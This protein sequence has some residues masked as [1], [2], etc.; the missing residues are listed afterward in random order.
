[1]FWV[2]Q[3]LLFLNVF[4]LYFLY[5]PLGFSRT[6]SISFPLSIK[7]K[8]PCDVLSAQSSSTID[9]LNCWMCTS[10]FSLVLIFVICLIWGI[11][12]F[13]PFF[14]F[15]WEYFFSTLFSLSLLIHFRFFPEAF[16]FC[17]LNSALEF[18]WPDSTKGRGG[19]VTG[20]AWEYLFLGRRFYHRSNVHTNGLIPGA[21]VTLSAFNFRLFHTK[22]ATSSPYPLLMCGDYTNFCPQSSRFLLFSFLVGTQLFSIRFGPAKSYLFHPL[23]PT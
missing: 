11:V 14:A 20:L 21:G 19:Q 1:V 6:S 16:V 13:S 15:L 17:N 9:T 22:C 2:S 18:D 5:P 8:N 12:F 7:K 4:R 10:L 23:T 3:F